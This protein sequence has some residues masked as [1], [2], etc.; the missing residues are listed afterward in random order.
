M[1][2]CYWCTFLLTLVFLS[3]NGR[4]W[5]KCVLHFVLS[6]WNHL[7]SITLKCREYS[8][9][10]EL[11]IPTSESSSCLYVMSDRK[12][13]KTFNNS[14]RNRVVWVE[15]MLISIKLR[16]HRKE[17]KCPSKLSSWYTSRILLW[18][19]SIFQ[20]DVDCNI[21]C[22]GILGEMLKWSLRTWY[23]LTPIFSQEWMWV[24][25]DGHCS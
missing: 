14:Y 20:S 11:E 9:P 10:M 17:E 19:C 1:K 5:N 2:Q 25:D 21:P 6:I 4:S 7:D 23:L 8:V 15:C 18:F 3:V 24:V 12:E 22:H 16:I 13:M